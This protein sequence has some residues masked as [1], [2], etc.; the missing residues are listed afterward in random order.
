M[1]SGK[2]LKRREI[3]ILIDG[4]ADCLGRL[5]SLCAGINRPDVDN[6]RVLKERSSDP[7]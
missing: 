1:G 6:A 5:A 7:S 2:L 3:E 4:D